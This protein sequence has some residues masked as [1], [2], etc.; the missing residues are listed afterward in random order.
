MSKKKHG[1][2][3]SHTSAAGRLIRVLDQYD[4]WNRVQLVTFNREIAY[5]KVEG[6]DG[7]FGLNIYDDDFDD[8]DQVGWSVHIDEKG[9]HTESWIDECKPTKWLAK[10]V[11]DWLSSQIFSYQC[12]L[13]TR[14]LTATGMPNVAALMALVQKQCWW[15]QSWLGGSLQADN[16]WSARLI[17]SSSGE[18]FSSELAENETGQLVLRCSGGD[19][20]IFLEDPADGVLRPRLESV[21]ECAVEQLAQKIRNW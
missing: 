14:F 20:D 9:K 4:I 13:V 15:R 12:S 17:R 3:W 10:Q 5:L 7:T 2:S 18:T 8:D 19:D 16:A 21:F 11:T 6:V 1:P